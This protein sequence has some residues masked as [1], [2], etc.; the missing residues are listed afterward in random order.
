MIRELSDRL[1]TPLAILFVRYDETAPVDW[2]RHFMICELATIYMEDALR[3][4]LEFKGGLE[5]PQPWG[6]R[7]RSI[8]TILERLALAQYSPVLDFGPKG[9]AE[10]AF[11]D[12]ISLRN[13]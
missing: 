4:Q 8:Q 10:K 11:R 6:L 9:Q 12:W 1:P 5:R 7:L 2:P 3:A 13:R